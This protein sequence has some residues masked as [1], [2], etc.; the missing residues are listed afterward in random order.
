MWKQIVQFHFHTSLF[1]ATSSEVLLYRNF[2]SY[3]KINLLY[4][5]FSNFIFTNKKKKKK[6]TEPIPNLGE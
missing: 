4:L 6:I 3:V 2:T 1:H 5:L